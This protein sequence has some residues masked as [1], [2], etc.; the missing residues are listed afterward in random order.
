MTKEDFQE[1]FYAFDW[2]ETPF[3][4]KDILRFYHRDNKAQVYFP[5]GSVIFTDK[6]GNPQ[7]YREVGRQ[8]LVNKL[9]EFTYGK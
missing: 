2:K 9:K 8:T 4:H 1:I 6:N 3:Q 5:G 7:T